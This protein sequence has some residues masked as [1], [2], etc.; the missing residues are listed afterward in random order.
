[1]CSHEFTYLI[2]FSWGGFIV[3]WIGWMQGLGKD[4]SG[5]TEPVQA[6]V[7]EDRPGLGSKQ[8][9]VE[10]T[11]EVQ[12]GNSY[13][14]RIQKKAL[15]KFCGDVLVLQASFQCINLERLSFSI[16]YIPWKS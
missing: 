1:M 9:K 13:R 7:M 16:S 12:A 8:R 3:S 14:T 15:A 4:G 6:K 10:S 5:I 11:L 2:W